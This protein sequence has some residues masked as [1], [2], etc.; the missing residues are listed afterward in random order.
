MGTVSIQG[1]TYDIFGTLSAANIY[2]IA[3]VGSS[4]WDS[5][6]DDDRKRSLVS[7][8]RLLNNVTWSGQPK[9]AGQSLAWPRTG[10]VD[11]D[12]AAV[13]D[14]VVPIG[15]EEACYELALLLL[16]GTD[17][18]DNPDSGSNIK[19][20]DAKGVS[21]EFFRPTQGSAT[22]LPSSV[23][24]YVRCFLAGAAIAVPSA[25]GT[26]VESQF[27]SDDEFGLTEGLK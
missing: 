13:D 25:T 23:N 27:D 22:L 20:V 12:G 24:R 17:A 1:N 2:F 10:V 3:R 16:S 9:V 8:T 14:T 7:A 19:K 26:D 15:V 6:D 4:S 18:I 11:C 5:A 21:V